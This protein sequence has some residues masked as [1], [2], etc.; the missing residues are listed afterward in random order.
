MIFRE[1]LEHRCAGQSAL[2]EGESSLLF[3]LRSLLWR[4]LKGE[5]QWNGRCNDDDDD[6]KINALN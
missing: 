5:N 3:T 1:E 4:N 6:N 2:E